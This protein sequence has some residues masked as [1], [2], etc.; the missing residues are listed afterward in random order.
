MHRKQKI[1]G[2]VGGLIF[3]F[4]ASGQALAATYYVSTSG[5]DSN[6]GT[7]AAPYKTIA[8]AYAK[9]SSGDTVLVKPGV[10]TE[11]KPEYAQVHLNKSGITV[12]SQVKWQAI[13]DGGAT[14]QMPLDSYPTAGGFW[15]SG[16]GNT[17]D[18]FEIRNQYHEGVINY[19]SN[20]TVTNNHIHHNGNYGDPTSIFG[21]DGVFSGPGARGGRYVGNYIHN[22]GRPTCGGNAWC[23]LDHGFYLKGDN[24]LVAN[25]IITN[26]PANGIQVAGTDTVSNLSI[27]NNTIAFN[28]RKP[29]QGGVLLWGQLSNIRIKN[30]IIYQNN[31]LGITSYKGHGSGVSIDKNIIFGNSAGV[32][33]LTLAGSDFSYNLGSNPN[34]DP[35][36]VGASGGDFGL[37]AGSPALDKGEAF[38]QEVPTDFTGKA[39]PEGGAYDLGAFE[40]AG[41][42]KDVTPDAGAGAMTGGGGS[43]GGGVS[44]GVVGIGGAGSSGPFGNCAR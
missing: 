6:P 7:E 5:S 15:I 26:N 41:P 22:N 31:S 32:M 44:G 17:V 8:A 25:N 23:N 3:S 20:S 9:A 30:N 27:L 12:K 14:K 13:L 42:K 4:A 10:Y 33:D 37:Q 2:F 38:A 18:G 36:F 43:A 39:R 19:G 28:G 11:F 1:F 16:T 21:H 40:G 24:E 34:Q 29:W 35:L